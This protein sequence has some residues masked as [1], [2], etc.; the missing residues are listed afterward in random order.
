MSSR[1]TIVNTIVDD[2]KQK[3]SRLNGYSIEPVIV[4]N[5]L[6]DPQT[7]NQFPALAIGFYNDQIEE[8]D[9]QTMRYRSNIL[10]MGYCQSVEDLYDLAED[11]E[12]F[13]Y[14][15][16]SDFTYKQQVQPIVGQGCRFRDRVRCD[17]FY[18]PAARRVSAPA[19]SVPGVVPLA[20]PRARRQGPRTL[21]V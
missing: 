18:V 14:N 6:V 7:V 4:Y 10:I 16:E 15:K 13:L 12:Y 1:L 5:Q 20:V 3:L 2:I 17:R 8:E 21:R 11:V 19:L 9:N